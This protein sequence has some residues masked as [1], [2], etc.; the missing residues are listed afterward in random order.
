MDSDGT[1]RDRDVKS[2]MKRGLRLHRIL[3]RLGL[4]EHPWGREYAK[5]HIG[6]LGGYKRPGEDGPGS[7][8]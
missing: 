7:A 6:L 3:V 5:G 2:S 8:E 1:L 4:L